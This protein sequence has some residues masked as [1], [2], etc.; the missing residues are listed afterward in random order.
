MLV[1]IRGKTGTC[2][3]REFRLGTQWR[4]IASIDA[5]VPAADAST[6]CTESTPADWRG[7]PRLLLPRL[8][9]RFAEFVQRH[10]FT[11]MKLTPTEE[12]VWDPDGKGPPTG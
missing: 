4:V 12:C 5:S 6:P 11:N 7:E 1:L 2:K 10:G 3:E 9:Q 8:H